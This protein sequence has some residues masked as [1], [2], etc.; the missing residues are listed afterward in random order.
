MTLVLE[1]PYQVRMELETFIL[2]ERGVTEA[3]N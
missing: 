3:V 2:D 1:L